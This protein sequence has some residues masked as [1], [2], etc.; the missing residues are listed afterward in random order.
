MRRQA[1]RRLHRN[2]GCWLDPEVD[3]W[4]FEKVLTLE[5][6]QVDA[7]FINCFGN[8]GAAPDAMRPPEVTEPVEDEERS[9][10]ESSSSEEEVPEVVQEV[11]GAGTLTPLA[12]P[13]P[14]QVSGSGIQ[15]LGSATELISEDPDL[16]HFSD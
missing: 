14:G 4:D 12:P 9:P 13:A 6:P 2:G 15:A 10:Q 5:G 1:F 7:K 16:E 3:C 11:P 8:S